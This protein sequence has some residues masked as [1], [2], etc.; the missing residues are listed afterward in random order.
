MQAAFPSLRGGATGAASAAASGDTPSAGTRHVSLGAGEAAGDEVRAQGARVEESSPPPGPKGGSDGVQG[1]ATAGTS[2]GA[3]ESAGGGVGGGGSGAV[4]TASDTSA[5]AQGERNR[6]GVAPNGGK[7]AKEMASWADEDGDGTSSAAALP[8]LTGWANEKGGSTGVAPAPANAWGTGWLGDALGVG[9]V[10]GEGRGGSSS[11]AGEA[12]AREAR[13]A[14]AP[15]ASRVVANRLITG[16]LSLSRADTRA[17]GEV[18]REKQALMEETK[19]R[20]EE[21][22]RQRRPW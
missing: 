21:Q 11:P 19:R 15:T 14:A 2:R 9:S 12:D 22:D 16:S 10:G 1:D 17:A 13:G 6:A 5:G 7:G 3:A 18:A 4:A 8:S 20:R